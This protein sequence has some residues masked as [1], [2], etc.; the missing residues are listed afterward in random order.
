[1]KKI[2]VGDLV[3]HL[4]AHKAPDSSIYRQEIGLVASFD[5]RDPEGA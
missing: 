5:E 3:K 4:D 2:K 1:M